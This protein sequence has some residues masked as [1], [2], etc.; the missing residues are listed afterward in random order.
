MLE[1]NNSAPRC[2]MKKD[3]RVC[4]SLHC[5]KIFRKQLVLEIW[6]TNTVFLFTQHLTHVL[7]LSEKIIVVKRLALPY[8]LNPKKTRVTFGKPLIYYIVVFK[9][10]T[11][12]QRNNNNTRNVL[13]Q[14]QNDSLH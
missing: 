10:T 12:L 4:S 6:S 11:S 13:A 5:D 3:S 2:S 7:F 9:L 8:E 1:N 14:F